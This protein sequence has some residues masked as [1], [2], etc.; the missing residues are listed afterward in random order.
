[1]RSVAVTTHTLC[2][3]KYS[4][5]V[6]FADVPPVDH[7]PCYFSACEVSAVRTDGTRSTDAVAPAA[8][9]M[10]CTGPPADL[11]LIDN[12]TT[13]R[14]QT[15]P[16]LRQCRLLWVTIYCKN[17]FHPNVKQSEKLILD[18]DPDKHQ[19]VITYRRLPLSHTYH[20]RSTSVN[21]FMSYPAHRQRA[22]QTNRSDRIA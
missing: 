17:A 12:K 2:V 4:S 10:A 9:Y 15:P 22:W 18:P 13:E 7:L 20:V 11:I 6:L 3:A 1:M 21:A 16:R 19:N 5:F 14:A 8:V